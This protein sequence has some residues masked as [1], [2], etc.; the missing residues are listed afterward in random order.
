MM[1]KMTLFGERS[2]KNSVANLGQ[3]IRTFSNWLSVELMYLSGRHVNKVKLWNGLNIAVRCENDVDVLEEVY[4][5][6][7]YDQNPVKI[8]RNAVVL[9]IGAHIGTFSLYAAQKCKAKTVYS[10]EP[11]PENFE[12]LKTNVKNNH[13]NATITPIG[14]AISAKCEKRDLFFTPNRAGWN[15][16]YREGDKDNPQR[17]SVQVDCI[18]LKHAL[19]ENGIEYVD[20]LKV[21][22][23]GAEYEIL[24]TANKGSAR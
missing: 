4:L 9:D 7:V 3:R 20:Y 11:F 22:C 14:K 21:D 18:T 10:F 19:E 13:L 16:F 23:E 24:Q 1:I 6:K 5:K 15:S 2:I 12:M 17:S 8:P